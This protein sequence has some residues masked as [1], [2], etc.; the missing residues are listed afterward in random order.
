M[1]SVFHVGMRKIKS[2]LAVLFSFLVWQFIRLFLPMLDVH[3]LFAYIYSV[4]EMR[5]TPE[6]TKNFGVLRIKVTLI[7]LVVGLIF[8]TISVWLTKSITSQT[9]KAVIEIA[10]IALATLTSLSAAEILDCKN[11]CGIA[12]II[13]VICMVVNSEKNIYFYAIMRVV[14]TLI[15]VASAMVVN[16]FIGKR[17]AE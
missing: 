15:G 17:Q 5:E 9:L 14:Q 13:T 6:K 8:I 3:P 7:G 12:A 4:V 10:I 11:F 1:N 16:K 2:V